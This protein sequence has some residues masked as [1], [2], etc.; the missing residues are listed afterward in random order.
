VGQTDAR[1]D[2]LPA[3][4]WAVGYTRIITPTLTN[5]MHVGMVHA[6][7]FQQ[8]IYGNVIGSTACTGTNTTSGSCSIPLEFGIQGIQQVANNGG[9]PSPTEGSS[10][11]I[12]DRCASDGGTPAMATAA[13]S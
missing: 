8:S 10:V 5:D 12:T 13:A 9:L 2:S 6:D 1:H 4:A 3:Y 7:K 11:S